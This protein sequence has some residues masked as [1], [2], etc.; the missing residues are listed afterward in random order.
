MKRYVALGCL[1]ALL[2]LSSNAEAQVRR[3]NY[4]GTRR[5][6]TDKFFN[7]WKFTAGTGLASYKGDLGGPPRAR[8]NPIHPQLYVGAQY[9]FTSRIS[10]RAEAGWYQISAEDDP[11][12]NPQRHL[13]FRSNNFEANIGAMFDLFEYT[14]RYSRTERTRFYPYG[15]V[16]IGITTFNPQA[17]YKGNWYNLRDYQT[18]GHKYGSVAMTYFPGVGVRYRLNSLLDISLEGSYR[19]TTTDYLDDVSNQYAALGS[20]PVKNAFIIGPNNTTP[21][22]QIFNQDFNKRGNPNSKDGYFLIS[23]KIE[24]KTVKD[25][26]FG[27]SGSSRKRSIKRRR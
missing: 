11:G 17:Q 26:N 25:G 1:T 3:N 23:A 10:A 5:S 12:K 4:K 14:R 13:S 19:F 2:C 24:F 27:G 20:D 7:I 6:I 15:F 8:V 18:E 21:L 9:R 16:G 22:D